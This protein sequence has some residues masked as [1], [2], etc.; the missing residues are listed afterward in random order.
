MA[1]VVDD[2]EELEAYDII[3]KGDFDGVLYY[4]VEWEHTLVPNMK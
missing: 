4:L 2:K 1:E 3:R